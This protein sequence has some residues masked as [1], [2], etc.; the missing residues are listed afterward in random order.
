M[1]KNANNRPKIVVVE[2]M[3]RCLR[4]S[5]IAAGADDLASAGRYPSNG[6]R[7]FAMSAEQARYEVKFADGWVRIANS[8]PSHAEILEHGLVHDLDL[9]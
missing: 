5:H 9:I 7:R 2:A 3:P 8:R 6:A 4:S 1:S